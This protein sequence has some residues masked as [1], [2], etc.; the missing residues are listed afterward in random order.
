MKEKKRPRFTIA[1][2]V[3]ALLCFVAFLV[4]GLWAHYTAVGEFATAH[5]AA[6]YTILALVGAAAVLLRLWWF[7]LLYYPGCA[8]AWAAGGFIAGLKGDF[9]PTAGLIAA[10]F[11]VAVFT[12]FGAIAQWR[13]FRRK[14]RRRR[15]ERE[16]EAI[17]AEEERRRNE[18]EQA[19]QE[20]KAAE[21]ALAAAA[22]PEK[23]EE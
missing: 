23:P 10:S 18:L 5:L 19:K 4:L 9:A 12:L 14:S 3:M 16:K 11:L 15:E 22:Q 7:A 17:Q 6:V 20:R 1:D 2:L 21:E 8:L 13:A